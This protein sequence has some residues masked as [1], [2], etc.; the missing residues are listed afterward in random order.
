MTQEIESDNIFHTIQN[1]HNPSQA[2]SVA[3]GPDGQ[4]DHREVGKDRESSPCRPGL[5]WEGHRA[6][7]KTRQSNASLGGS[8]ETPSFVLGSVFPSRG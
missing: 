1:D 7:S 3:V 6:G 8:V 2:A 4:V 5:S